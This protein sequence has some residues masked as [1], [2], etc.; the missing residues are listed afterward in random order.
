MDTDTMEKLLRKAPPVRTPANLLENLQSDI[1]LP[2]S[3]SRTTHHAPRRSNG[4]FRRWMPALGFA[5]WFLGC[6][7]AFGIQSGWIAQLRERQR[8]WETAQTGAAQQALAAEASR[9]AAATEL[10]QLKKD[11]ADVRRLRVELQQLRTDTEELTALR[12]Q[13][14]QLRNELKAQTVAPAKAEEDFFAVALDRASQIKCTTHLKQLGLA[15]R[16]WANSSKSD[17]MPEGATLKAALPNLR[18]DE[19]ILVCPSDGTTSYQILGP[20][21]PERRP[22]IVFSHCPIHNSFGLSDGSV[23][24]V[25]TNQIQAVQKDGWWI[26]ERR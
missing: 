15:A 2:P 20:G 1:T 21:A 4:W 22:E 17:A 9:V 16:M 14:Q 8:A 12:T 26:L 11:L 7:A 5:L 13:N 24:H 19:K 10:E 6:I 25:G 23:Q 18:F 3:D